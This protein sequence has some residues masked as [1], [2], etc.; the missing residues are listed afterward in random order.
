MMGGRDCSGSDGVG[1]LGG[2][3]GGRGEW[4]CVVD[5]GVSVEV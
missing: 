2:G 5:S 4:Q 3:G 1:G